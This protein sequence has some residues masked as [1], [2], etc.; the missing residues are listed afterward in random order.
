MQVKTFSASDIGEFRQKL[1]DSLKVFYPTLAIVFT[2]YKF[3]NDIQ[4]SVP[5][6]IK[7]FGA[8]SAGEISDEKVLA[9]GISVMLTDISP[10]YFE[11]YIEETGRHNTFEIAQNAA[12]RGKET[13]DKQAFLVVSSGL[14]TDGMSIIEGITDISGEDV[15][16]FGGLAGDDFRFK[17]TYIFDNEKIISDGLYFLIF[18]GN[19]ILLDGLAYNGWEPLGLEKI[20]TKSKGNIVYEIDYRPIKELY[21]EFYNLDLTR[22]MNFD[23][24]T[25]Y[26][27]LLE[28]AGRPYV[29]RTPLVTL[30]DGAFVFAGRMPQ[31]AKIKFTI[32]P[33]LEII[34]ETVKK[35]EQLKKERIPEADAIFMFSCAGRLKAFSKFIDDEIKGIH[36]IWNKPLIGFFS[37][38]EI[39]KATDGKAD[40]HNETCTVAV[41][42]EL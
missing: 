35:F 6:D 4:K 27:L 26:P 11:T 33:S 10:S 41:L 36:Q 2:S 15:P 21:Y 34:K 40:F 16:L 14:T 12:T 7:I 31:G 20:I 23:L 42:K 24:A 30:P 1:A 19:K 13:F 5:K 32:P 17:E 39:G 18:D 25:R 28:R 3:I 29:M 38:G 8:S 22:P 37:Y 9:K